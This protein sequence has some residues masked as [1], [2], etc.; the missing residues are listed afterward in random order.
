[1]GCRA[2]NMMGR[3]QTP[4]MVFLDAFSFDYI[5]QKVFKVVKTTQIMNNIT[6]Y[7]ISSG[8]K[9]NYI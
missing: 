5:E 9:Y 3:R 8:Q 1:M 6:K 2:P 4:S 7:A